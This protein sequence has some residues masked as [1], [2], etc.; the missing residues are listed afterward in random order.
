MK[1]RSLAR[2]VALTLTVRCALA[3]A[4]APL[5]PL[6]P[7]APRP[8]VLHAP[9]GA[10]FNQQPITLR[11]QFLH[12]ELLE[13]VL[14]SWRPRGEAAWRALPCVRH[15]DVWRADLPA[16]PVRV[17]AVEY[18]VTAL[19]LAGQH[20]AVMASAEAPHVVVLRPEADDEQERA[21]LRAHRG[22]RL[23]FT[24]GGEVTDFGARDNQGGL[25]CG[26]AAG[27]RCR[28][29]WYLVY[30][31]ARYRFHRQVRSVAVRVDRLVGVTTRVESSAPVE[32]DVGLVAATTEVEFRLAPT[33][34]LA[35]QGILGA[36]ELTVQ[37]G[38]GARLEFGTT[39]PTRLQLSFQGVTSYGVLGS[40]WM[41]WDTVRDTPL[42]AGVEVTTQ[43]GANTSP[44]VR[45]L[46][47]AGRHFGRYVTVTLRGGYGARRE[48]AGGFTGGASVQLAL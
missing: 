25:G 24:A 4:Q 38:G 6:S 11:F 46:V 47:E 1:P 7:P 30:G 35:V 19:T 37:G 21:D 26:A 44:G 34:S 27:A 42:G 23:E 43:P 29:W 14:V 8:R 22:H 2:T 16:Q 3:S 32:R 9:R 17:R 20:L 12:G 33:I 15:E 45:L 40:A 31:Q 41:R 28:D 39:L 48:D 5:T 13:R 36:N 10:A 18:H